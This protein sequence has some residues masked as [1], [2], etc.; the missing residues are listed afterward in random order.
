MILQTETDYLESV[1]DNT[2]IRKKITEKKKF[3][4]KNE[5]VYF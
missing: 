5:K 4:K 1:F 3:C 2:K